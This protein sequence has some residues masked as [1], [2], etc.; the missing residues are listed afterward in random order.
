MKDFSKETFDILIQAGQS[1]SEGYGFGNVCGPYQPDERV[2]YFNGDGTFQVAQEKV[3]NNGVQSNFSLTFARKYIESGMLAEGRK[4]LILRT[5]VGGT[6]FS[7]NHWKS[8]DDLYLR[9][10]D[11]IRESL[12]LNPEN[13]LK[14][15]LWHQGETDACN[16]MTYDYYRGHLSALVESVRGTFGVPELPF[17]AGDFVQDWENDNKEICAPIIAA[18]REV[19]KSPFSAFVETDGLDSNRQDGYPHPLG[20]TDSIHFCRRAI[21]ALGE[22]YFAAYA[23]I[24]GKE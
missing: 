3:A 7:D 10:M 14:A 4:L 1:N 11:M 18:L 22:R 8:T 5:A 9:M 23:A 20:W 16:K 6:G 17:I 12:A 19:C 21:Y 24:V 15:L 13:R 2:W